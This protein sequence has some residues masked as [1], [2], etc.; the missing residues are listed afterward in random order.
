MREN[1][2]NNRRREGGGGGC[3]G[4]RRSQKGPPDG[5][6]NDLKLKNVVIIGLTI[7]MHFQQFED[8]EFQNFTGELPPSTT[9]VKNFC[10]FGTCMTYHS[11]INNLVTILEVCIRIP[12][13]HKKSWLLPC[14]SNG[15][16]NTVKTRIKEQMFWGFK[17]ILFLYIGCFSA[18]SA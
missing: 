4:H 7:S 12:A 17:L 10:V 11:N 3:A 6:V 2:K 8:Q 13:L 5:L 1:Y 18:K 9:P 14:N 16:D 15:Y